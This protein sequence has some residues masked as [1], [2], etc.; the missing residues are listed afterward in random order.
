MSIGLSIIDVIINNDNSWS[1]CVVEV[2]ILFVMD[3]RK[4]ERKAL[5]ECKTT[6]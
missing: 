5:R 2:K 3:L 6:L 4:N 1:S